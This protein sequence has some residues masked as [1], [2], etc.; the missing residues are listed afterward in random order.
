VPRWLRMNSQA[1]ITAPRNPPKDDRL[2][3]IFSRLTG[4]RSVSPG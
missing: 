4:S 1:P 2:A 3:Q